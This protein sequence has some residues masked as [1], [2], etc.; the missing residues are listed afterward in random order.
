MFTSESKH[1]LLFIPF[2]LLIGMAKLTVYYSNHCEGCKTL[3]PRLSEA[4]KKR[5][6]KLE[7]INI[8]DC[9]SPDC[10]RVEFVPAVYRDGKELSDRELEGLL[11]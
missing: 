4:A 10:N 7:K 2:P 8:E 6:L 1:R 5:G 9:S 3:L 11:K